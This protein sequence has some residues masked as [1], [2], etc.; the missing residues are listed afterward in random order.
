MKKFY[1]LFL[2]LFI[3]SSAFSQTTYDREFRAVWI[4][5]VFGL[6]WP[7]KYDT[8]EAQKEKLILMLDELERLNFN[9]VFLQVR[10][11]CDAF[12]SSAY[13]PWSRYLTGNVGGEP[14]YDPLAFAIE[15]AH[16]RGIELHAWLNPYRVNASTSYTYPEEH[17]SKKHPE[18]I[19]KYADG[20]KILDPGIPA[21]SE[22]ISD[23]VADVVANY[24]VDGIHFDDYFYSYNGTTSEDK[25]TFETYGADYTNIGDWRRNNITQMLGKV[26]RRI[27][28]LK[29]SVRFGISPFGIWK[30]NYPQGIVGMNAYNQIYADALSWLGVDVNSDTPVGIPV[31]DYLTP[32]LY[33]PI[34]GGQDYTSLVSWWADQCKKAERHLY[35][36]HEL[37]YLDQDV[38][39]AATARQSEEY[40]QDLHELKAYM[41]LS[42]LEANSRLQV[43]NTVSSENEIARQ[44]QEDRKEENRNKNSLGS[45]FFRAQ[46]VMNGI[47]TEDVFGEAY[48][49]VALPPAMPWLETVV[50][51][52]PSDLAIV[53][54]SLIWTDNSKEIPNKK[55]VVYYGETANAEAVVIG[56]TYG[57]SIHISNVDLSNYEVKVLSENNMWEESELVK[58]NAPVVTNPTQLE[59]EVLEAE[60]RIDWTLEEGSLGV[61]YQWATTKDFDEGSIVENRGTVDTSVTFSDLILGA[62]YYFRVRSYNSLAGY[63]DWTEEVYHFYLKKDLPMAPS[64]LDLDESNELDID[65]VQITWEYPMG[66]NSA[67]YQWATTSDFAEESILLDEESEVTT[68]SFSELKIGQKYYFRIRSNSLLGYGEWSNTYLF[69][70]DDALL[71]SPQILKPTDTENELLDV[72]TIEITWE[73]PLGTSSGQYQW[74]TSS[75]FEESTILESTETQETDFS[76]TLDEGINYYFRIR[77][78]AVGSQSEWSAIYH[79]YVKEKIPTGTDD[80]KLN[81]ALKQ[82]YPNPAS[83]MTTVAFELEKRS[84]VQLLVHDIIGNRVYLKKEGTLEA[85]SHKLSLDVSKW[86][87]GIYFYSIIIDDIQYTKKM[88]IE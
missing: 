13:E 44:I 64:L 88:V 49:E 30:P 22:Y 37:K 3:T 46:Q 81:R 38:A 23:V 19:L 10:T 4:A 28:E 84:E 1:I 32:Q 67:N 78:N 8:A 33:W 15:E 7:N 83:D 42:N 60:V 27:K 24:D 63:G 50:P 53:G 39:T 86:T 62:D 40:P 2:S 26:N 31:V 74:A 41:N 45:V 9:A 34:G 65:H 61:E 66:V 12:Y 68:K 87:S 29:P 69:Y 51:N 17:V 55:F 59:N 20:K 71:V 76:Y 14:E 16:K 85:G 79:F 70:M 48:A 52:A 73:Y 25:D 72:G 5:T 80:D 82:N 36:G 35:S 75:A 6:D 21:V 11:E 58:P 56:L 43:Q 47:N 54:D 18:W 77:S 57:T